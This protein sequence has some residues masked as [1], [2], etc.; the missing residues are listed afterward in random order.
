MKI[1]EPYLQTVEMALNYC[2]L[3]QADRALTWSPALILVAT[4]VCGCIKLCIDAHK[5]HNLL[6]FYLSPVLRGISLTSL[7]WNAPSSWS[8]PYHLSFVEKFTKKSIFDHRS[9]RKW[10]ARSTLKILWEKETVDPVVWF[11]E[12]TVKAIWRNASSLE[13]S[14]KHQDNTWLVARRALPLRSSMYTRHGLP[15]WFW[16]N[17]MAPFHTT[18]ST[19]SSRTPSA[20]GR[21]NLPLSATS[22]RRYYTPLEQ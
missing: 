19:V 12:Q 16:G 17:R 13:L 7:L 10:S 20:K 2:N 22:E 15:W 9:I 18:S 21:A 3:G 14:N 8:I 6:K 4:F 11:P 5:C 1:R